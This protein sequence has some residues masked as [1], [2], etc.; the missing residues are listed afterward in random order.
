MKAAEVHWVAQWDPR[1]ATEATFPCKSVMASSCALDEQMAP[2]APMLDTSGPSCG[3]SY[4]D[5]ILATASLKLFT[6]A[7]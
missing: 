3:I 6:M 1:C 4:A 7:L 2:D 5:I